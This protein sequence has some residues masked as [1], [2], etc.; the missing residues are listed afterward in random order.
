MT[1]TEYLKKWLPRQPAKDKDEFIK[2]SKSMLDPPDSVIWV[3][4][5]ISHRDTRP[6]VGVRIGPFAFQV[7]PEDA[8]KIGRDFY[9]VAGGA[10][11]DAFLFQTLTGKVGLPP[12]T[13]FALINELREWRSSRLNQPP[14]SFTAQ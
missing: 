5:V 2:D 7:S 12:E 11:N 8:R 3:E 13:A 4:S 1:L 6:V 10:E 9:E 14:A